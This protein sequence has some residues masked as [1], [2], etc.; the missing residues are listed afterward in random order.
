MTDLENI[1][2]VDKNCGDCK[3]IKPIRGYKRIVLNDAVPTECRNSP[4]NTFSIIGNDPKK[5]GI[6]IAQVTCAYPPVAPTFPACSKFEQKIE[7]RI[8]NEVFGH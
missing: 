2:W 6:L 8:K 1:D 5:P 3:F 4:P 7:Q